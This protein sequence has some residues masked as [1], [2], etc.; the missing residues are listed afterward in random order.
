MKTKITIDNA[1]FVTINYDDAFNGDRIARTFF[2]PDQ[3][4][5]VREQDAA[6]RY[7]QVCERLGSMGNTLSASSRIQLAEVIRREYRAMRRA[8]AR[9]AL[10][11][12]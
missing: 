5:Y 2:C 7:P 1:G 9:E 11:N 6:G 12:Y 4:G 10:R 8:E 3:G